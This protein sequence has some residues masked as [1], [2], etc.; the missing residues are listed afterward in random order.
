MI[1]CFVVKTLKSGQI[2]EGKLLTGGPVIVAFDNEPTQIDC[3]SLEQSASSFGGNV[4]VLGQ[5]HLKAA[6]ASERGYR[7]E[8]WGGSTALISEINVEGN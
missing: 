3:E 1:D 2:R 8:F 6:V 5:L 7:V 4:W